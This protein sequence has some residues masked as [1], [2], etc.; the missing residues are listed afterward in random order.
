MPETAISTQQ[1]EAEYVNLGSA[2]TLEPE[3]LL[4]GTQIDVLEAFPRKRPPGAW[5]RE[6]LTELGELI[7]LPYNWDS[8]GSSPIDDRVRRHAIRLLEVLARAQTARPSLAPTSAG[9]IELEWYTPSLEIHLEI[10]PGNGNLQLFYSGAQVEEWEGPLREAP[11]PIEQ[12]LWDVA[13][14]A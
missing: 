13:H 9:G 6:A 8:H 5:L 14:P 12:L 3:D 10:E 7:R 11:E 2:L 1:S 4:F